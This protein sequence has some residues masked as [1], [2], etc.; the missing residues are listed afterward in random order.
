MIDFT[1]IN[2]FPAASFLREVEI[3]NIRV[4]NEN[5]LLKNVIGIILIGGVALGL[6]AIYKKQKNGTG[7]NE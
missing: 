7:K 5:S 4:K 1:K 3:E 2:A 6:A